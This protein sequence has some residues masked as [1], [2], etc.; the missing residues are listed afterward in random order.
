MAVDFSYLFGLIFSCCSDWKCKIW[1]YC[2]S[3]SCSGD[4]LDGGV[5]FVDD[6]VQFGEII[7][8]WA[9]IYGCFALFVDV[10]VYAAYFIDDYDENLAGVVIEYE[11]FVVFNGVAVFLV[12]FLMVE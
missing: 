8:D 4:V 3:Y 9:T 11:K 2:W 12:M 10:F 7:V 6:A 1:C 5:V